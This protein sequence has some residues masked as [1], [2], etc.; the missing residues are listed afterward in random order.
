MSSSQ[1]RTRLKIIAP[2]DIDRFACEGCGGCCRSWGI[3]VDEP[4]F[5]RAKAFLENPPEPRPNP[6][7]PWYFEDGG[8]KYYQL[9]DKGVCVFLDDNK[10]CYLHKH[11]PMLKSTTCRDYPREAVVTPRGLELSMSFSSFGA[12]LNVLSRPAGFS[13]IEAEMDSPSIPTEPAA[14]PITTP[15]RFS[16]ETYAVVED[17]L[18]K[19]I[20][21]MDSLDDALI[22]TARFLAVV[23]QETDGRKL[24]KKLRRR[25]LHPVSFM[26]QH[27]ISNLEAAYNLIEKIL[28]F[29]AA[30]LNGCAPLRADAEK[31]QTL[32]DD[33]VRGPAEEKVGRALFYR[34]LGRSWFDPHASVFSPPLRKFMQY[35]IFKKTFFMEFG[36]VRGFNILCFMY[37]VIRMRLMIRAKKEN[38]QPTMGDLF[39]PV[40]FVELYF[41]H[42]GKFL[43]FWKEVFQSDILTSPAFA[44]ILVR[45]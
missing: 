25:E 41:S 21:Q 11:D 8:K 7:I 45:L 28:E 18:L 2:A 44:E 20:G 35:K 3:Y 39:D 30:F 10:R 33:M 4:S 27:P 26:E 40:H 12:F 36:F 31:V 34:R 6:N 15:K 23:E 14:W 5:E 9:T 37:A 29:R 19:F 24:R 38:R 42:S 1:V 43:Q 13:L 32:I 22:A 17:I 16:W